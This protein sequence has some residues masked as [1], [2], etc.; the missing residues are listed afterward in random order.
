MRGCSQKEAGLAS[1]ALPLLSSAIVPIGKTVGKA[2][3]LGGIASQG[4]GS[5]FKKTLGGKRKRKRK[6]LF[7]RKVTFCRYLKA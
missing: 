7:K 5:L 3:F 1:L 6:S 4:I 2:V